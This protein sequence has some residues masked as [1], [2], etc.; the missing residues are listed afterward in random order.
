[1]TFDSVRVALRGVLANRMRSA[2]T[3]LGILIGTSAVILLVGVGT[4]I[5]DNVQQQIS[6]LGT[7]S[8]YVIPERNSRGRDRGGTN[9]RRVRLTNADVKA[10]SDPV[11]ASALS[12]VTP[13]YSASGTVTWEGTT[14]SLNSFLGAEPVFGQV[15]NAAV[16]RG[17]W[18]DDEDVRS[19]AKVA[20]A[21]LT[22][23]DKLFGKGVDPIGEQVEF[24]GVRFRIIG[25]LDKKGSNGFQD[26]DDVMVAPISTVRENIV[27]N[28]DSY[29][30]IAIQAVS[31]D[32]LPQA[33]TQINT[34]LRRTHRIGPTQPPDFV[35]FN[36]ANLL[37]AGKAAAKQFQLLLAV[38]A[39]ISLLIGGIGVM[40]IMLVTVT[41]R[42]REI[43]IR[44]AL[45]AQ[46]SDILSQFLVE[47]MILAGL[48]GIFG[49]AIGVGAGQ[50]EG[51]GLNPVISPPAVVLSFGV[52]ILIGI[53]FGIYPASRA[54]ALTPMEAL[55][56]E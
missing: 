48:G 11:R 16:A 51:A 20:V 36:A 41:E 56:Y 24:N 12:A 46:R 9:A 19:R 15:R 21:G 35:V 32:A 55:R 38:V 22:V 10:L 18:I 37:A 2:L 26:Q 44:K 4:G 31:R 29:N 28:V 23:V 8:I 6:S 30:I 42:T 7:N 14:Y 52:S 13:T 50:F 34:I 53:F 43:G 25:V 27:G 40:N 47:A 5:S 45:G 17:R 33:M 49:V 54:A 3:M 39:C 1:V